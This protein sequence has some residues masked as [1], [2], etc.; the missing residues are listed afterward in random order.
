VQD[1]VTIRP[2]AA[3]DAEE[4][5]KLRCDLWPEGV[6]DHEAEIASFFGSTLVEPLAVFVAV[7]GA[8]RV[9][10]FAELSIRRDIPALGYYDAGFIEGLYVAPEKRFCGVAR[11]LVQ[12]GRH[13]ARTRGCKGFASDRSG[14]YVIDMRYGQATEAIP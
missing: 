10:G 14:R 8:D 11:A 6:E 4:W 9:I 5:L 3:S 13:W 7:D 12:A 2:V 1:S